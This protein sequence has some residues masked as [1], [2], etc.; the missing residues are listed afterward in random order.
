MKK[1]LDWEK[2]VLIQLEKTISKGD[3]GVLCEDV[4]TKG[5]SAGYL[6]SKGAGNK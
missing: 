6:C 2:P 5:N 4:C 3:V 1:K